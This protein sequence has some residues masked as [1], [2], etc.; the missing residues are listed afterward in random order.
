MG[1]RRRFTIGDMK[2][3]ARKRGGECLSETYRYSGL[4]WNCKKGHPTWWATPGAIASGSW[5][6]LCVRARI[7]ASQRNSISEYQTIARE[8]GG[9]LLSTEYKNNVQKL[10]WE[11]GLGHKWESRA[12]HVKRGGWCP[13]CS[14]GIG[15]RICRQYFEHLFGDKFPKTRPEWL[16]GPS[17]KRMELDGY[18]ERLKIA[19]EHHGS[20][21]FTKKTIFITTN[22]MLKSRKEADKLKRMLCRKNGVK[23]IEIPEVPKLTSIKNLKNTIYLQCKINRIAIP[24]GFHSKK[25]SLRDAFHPKDLIELKALAKRKGGKLLSTQYMGVMTPH[26]WQCREG[27]T[28]LARPNGVKRNSWCPE[29]AGSK[30]L[31]IEVI[32]AAAKARGGKCLTKI[33]K[34][35]TQAIQIR[36]SKNHTW[37]TNGARIRHGAWCPHCAGNVRKK[38]SDIKTLAKRY[39]GICL[40]KRY[41]NSGKKLKWRCKRGHR[42]ALEPG[43]VKQGHWCKTCAIERR[44]DRTRLGMIAMKK[45]A[46]DRGGKCLS[47]KYL[48]NK[49]KLRW[50]CRFGHRWDASPGNVK[51]QKTW[52]PVCAGKKTSK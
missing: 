20:Q 10:S 30:K 19:F 33:Y 29:C 48:C 4:L 46:R 13:I 27:H 24:R 23:L 5:C 2:R 1:R 45:I 15:E 26:E 8:R 14:T 34:N 21:H 11:C 35:C 18:C 16:T 31:S 41:V 22:Q 43:A 28:W 25:V 37:S 9:K 51:N 49:D 47:R 42:F 7:A 32:K 52:C 50:E 36:C 40:S 44:T 6:K 17:G 39:G 3:L 38:I 12:L